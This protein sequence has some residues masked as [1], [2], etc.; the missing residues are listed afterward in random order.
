MEGQGN[1]ENNMGLFSGNSFDPTGLMDQLN[2]EGFE[3]RSGGEK[4]ECG[5]G[6]EFEVGLVDDDSDH[7]FQPT[8]RKKYHRHN[9]DQIQQLESF[10]E[11]CPHP[12]EK[13]RIELSHVLGLESKQIKFWFQNRRT[14][15]KVK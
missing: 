7:R 1:G 14:Q 12:D 6:D 8:I 2:E 4:F 13:Q 11:E 9:P 10:F 15:L 5:S 3:K